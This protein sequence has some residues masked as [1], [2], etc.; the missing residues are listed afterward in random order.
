MDRAAF[1]ETC[2]REGVSLDAFS[3]GA[4]RTEAYCMTSASDRDFVVYYSERGH[5]RD[6]RIYP[7]DAD[8]FADL[9]AR[10]L[11]DPTTRVGYRET[12]RWPGA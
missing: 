2:D 10:L 5:K 1:G 9:L 3:V 12:H 7:N 4:D 6:E 11:R 8:A